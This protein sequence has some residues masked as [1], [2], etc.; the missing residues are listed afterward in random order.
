[1]LLGIDS[2]LLVEHRVAQEAGRNA[3]LERRKRQQIT[4]QLLDGEL[5]EGHIPVEGVD[6]PVAIRPDRTRQ[7]LF[8]TVGVGITRRVE[9]PPSPAL[10]VMGR[11]EQPLDQLLISLG[12]LVVEK[13]VALFNR[14]RQTGK[15]KT[16]APDQGFLRRFR[17]RS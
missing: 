9:P 10:A 6:D 1:K 2:T 14:G 11:R 8:K 16:E 5:V 3:L 15:I 17:R 4:R 12:A 13:P 7:I